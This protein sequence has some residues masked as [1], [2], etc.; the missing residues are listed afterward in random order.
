MPVALPYLPFPVTEMCYQASYASELHPAPV[1]KFG[2]LDF[3]F[4][5]QG[6]YSVGAVPVP[7]VSNID[8][9]IDVAE[10][11]LCTV[12]HDV[13]RGEVFFSRNDAFLLRGR[14]NGMELGW[15]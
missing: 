9:R 12:A 3:G 13:E 14:S 5:L 11:S 7:Q 2:G 10:K 1:S 8:S 15:G 4:D 6:A